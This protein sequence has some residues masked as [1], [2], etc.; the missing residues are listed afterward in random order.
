MRQV[1]DAVQKLVLGSYLGYI[2][3]MDVKMNGGDL[4][5]S[6]YINFKSKRNTLRQV[7]W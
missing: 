2:Q 3:R 5:P 7:L 6:N 4:I 1:N